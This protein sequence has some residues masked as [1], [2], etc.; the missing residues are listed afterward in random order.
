MVIE[1]GLPFSEPLVITCTSYNGQA[2][3]WPADPMSTAT[4]AGAPAL[5]QLKA[6][7]LSSSTSTTLTVFVDGKNNI[8]ETI[9]LEV[10]I[11]M[12]GT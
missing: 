3:L 11:R 4:T 8:D 12:E 1:V 9:V 6:P 10:S 2:S 7:R 5:P